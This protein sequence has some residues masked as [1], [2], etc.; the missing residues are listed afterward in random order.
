M[1]HQRHT[2]ELELAHQL[3]P[4]T[5]HRSLRALHFMLLLPGSS[6][7]AAAARAARR[8]RIL[9]PA[10]A[11]P[12]GL[13]TTA[14]ASAA[15]ATSLSREDSMAAAGREVAV[16]GG[17]VSGL[18][19]ASVLSKHGHKVTV[20]DL[21]KH[22]PGECGRRVC[23]A[24]SSVRLALSVRCRRRQCITVPPANPRRHTTRSHT[25]HPV[26]RPAD[27]AQDELEGAAV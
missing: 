13:S 4:R 21:G 23:V 25:L 14:P 22:A 10:A 8:L 9:L 20:F 3:Q 2:A 5:D 7:S 1:H 12:A 17:G 19:C 18:F 27:D 6:A 24:S 15:A 26:R 11:V 16:V